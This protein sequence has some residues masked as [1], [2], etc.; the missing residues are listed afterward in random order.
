MEIN[1]QVGENLTVITSR[2]T[3]GINWI[4]ESENCIVNIDYDKTKTEASDPHLKK[5]NI[6]APNVLSASI[7]KLSEKD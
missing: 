6:F 2:G 1:L 3:V 4:N 7:V 5:E